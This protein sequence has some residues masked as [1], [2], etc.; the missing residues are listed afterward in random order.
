[1]KTAQKN[2]T[3][4]QGTTAKGKEATNVKTQNRPNIT[5]KEAKEDKKDETAKDQKPAEAQK[6]EATQI[7]EAKTGNPAPVDHQPANVA[8]QPKAEELKNEEPKAEVRY[9]K[10]VMN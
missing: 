7:A 10:P 4:V 5:G 1:M 2:A 6:V 3:G 9:I 8:E